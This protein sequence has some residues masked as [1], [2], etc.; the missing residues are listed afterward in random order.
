MEQ[1]MQEM[2]Q[3]IV[4]QN[5]K[6][7]CWNRIQEI[8]MRTNR[9]MGPMPMVGMVGPMSPIGMGMRPMGMGL[10]SSFMP[11]LTPPSAPPAQQQAPLVAPAPPVVAAPPEPN[12][13]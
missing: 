2:Q 13:V 11:T 7:A 4:M 5:E 3:I 9:M 8:D 6:L 1:K 12:P 10:S